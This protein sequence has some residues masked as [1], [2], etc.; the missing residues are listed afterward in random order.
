MNRF[1]PYEKMSKKNQRE[2]DNYGRVIF[3][4][5]SCTFSHKSIK[6]YNR[7]NY[8]RMIYEDWDYDEEEGE[9]IELG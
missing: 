1:V 6:D 2:Y 5:N 7:Q 8:K 9:E 3:S 4:K